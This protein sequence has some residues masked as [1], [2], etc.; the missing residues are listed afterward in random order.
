MPQRILKTPKQLE[1]KFIFILT[2]LNSVITCL[3]T[4]CAIGLRSMLSSN[5]NISDANI[6]IK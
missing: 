5:E 4:S 2:D 1:F 3:P 6:T